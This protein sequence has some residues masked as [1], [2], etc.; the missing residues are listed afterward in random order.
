PRR[1]GGTGSRARGRP[2]VRARG[3]ARGRGGQR[4]LRTVGAGRTGAAVA[5]TPAALGDGLAGHGA[6]GTR[7]RGRDHYRGTLRLP[8]RGLPHPSPLRISDGVPGRARPTRG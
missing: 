5:G 8:G 6:R 2:A 7:P 3:T 1:A 4:R